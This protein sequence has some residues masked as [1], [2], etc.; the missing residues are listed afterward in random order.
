[1]RVGTVRRS[2]PDHLEA[3][4]GDSIDVCVGFGMRRRGSTLVED[5]DA[6]FADRSASSVEL[7]KAFRN[8]CLA[9]RLQLQDK[10]FQETTMAVAMAKAEERRHNKGSLKYSTTPLAA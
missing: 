7:C 4:G 3:F 8:D 6:G 1:M 9:E 5:V 10:F 2:S